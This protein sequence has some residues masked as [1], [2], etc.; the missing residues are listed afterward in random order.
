MAMVTRASAVTIPGIELV[1]KLAPSTKRA[2][3]PRYRTATQANGKA[4]TVVAAA[5]AAASLGGWGGAGA[6]PPGAQTAGPPIHSQRATVHAGTP[7]ASTA[8]AVSVMAAGTVMP[9]RRCG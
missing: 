7:S 4:S 2:K 6:I 5:A 8:S 3:N 1:T 9:R